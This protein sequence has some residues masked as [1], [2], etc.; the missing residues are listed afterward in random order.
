VTSSWSFHILQ[1]VRFGVGSVLQV[2]LS[3]KR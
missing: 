3:L 1:H 2:F